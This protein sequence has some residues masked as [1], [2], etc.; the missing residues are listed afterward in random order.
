MPDTHHPTMWEY[1]FPLRAD[2]IVT[3]WLPKDL[4]RSEVARIARY[5]D[6]LA[7]IDELEVANRPPP[8]GNP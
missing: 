1:E 3:L 8:S 6:A 5:L 2:C 4:K 7:P